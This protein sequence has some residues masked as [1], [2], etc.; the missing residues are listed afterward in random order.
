MFGSGQS[1]IDVLN[2]LIKSNYKVVVTSERSLFRSGQFSMVNPLRLR[3]VRPKIKNKNN[4]I[5]SLL[6]NLKRN[7]SQS[8]NVYRG[9]ELALVDSM[10]SHEIFYSFYSELKT[11]TAIIVRE[12]PDFFKD[13]LNEKDI[14]WAMN[15]LSIYDNYIFVSTVCRTKWFNLGLD[16]N[17]RSFYIPNCCNEKSVEKIRKKTRLHFRQRLHLPMDDFIVVCL[18]S[19]QPRK[20]QDLLI[21][22]M[23]RLR[24]KIPSIVVFIIGPIITEWG[25]ALRSKIEQAGQS[26]R[27]KMIDKKSNALEYVYASNLFVLPSRAEAMP[28]TILEAMALGTA[29]VASD[30]DGIP[31]LIDHEQ[32][33]LLFPKDDIEGLID[34]ISRIACRP[35][36]AERFRKASR[37]KYWSNFSREHQ[38]QRFKPA[39]NEMLHN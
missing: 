23:D 27:L 2:S 12:S 25:E 37:K 9:I 32:T 35:A 6:H 14:S 33:G 38:F 10:G 22:A 39:L 13:G 15:A 7:V 17:K 8:N 19:V 1:S 29:V 3:W 26:A 30:V 34:C 16:T 31:E 21:D 24:K 20:G 18:A 4:N 36:D 28:R 11:E 5:L